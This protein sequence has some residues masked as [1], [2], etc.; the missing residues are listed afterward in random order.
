MGVK[1]LLQ[2]C[3]LSLTTSLAV[4][5]ALGLGNASVLN[6][7][8][9]LHDRAQL[10]SGSGLVSA[11]ITDLLVQALVLLGLVL[12]ILFHL[13]LGQLVLLCVLLVRRSRI[14]FLCLLL[15]QVLRE[16]ALAHFEN[17]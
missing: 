5:I 14:G 15:C 8:V 2:A 3:N 12:H 10:V 16:I 4:F 17:V 6:A 9:V 11:K 13:G 7:T 1:S